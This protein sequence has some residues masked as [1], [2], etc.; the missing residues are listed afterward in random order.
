MGLDYQVVDQVMQED[1]LL[2][3]ILSLT[4]SISFG[5][6]WQDIPVKPERMGSKPEKNLQV[7]MTRTEPAFPNHSMSLAGQYQC[8]G[9]SSLSL[10]VNLPLTL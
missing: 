3:P 4:H 8:P 10:R 9:T 5:L 6:M 2:S 1:G 7:K